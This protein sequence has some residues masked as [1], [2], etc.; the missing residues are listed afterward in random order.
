MKLQS[1]VFN[2]HSLTWSGLGVAIAA[3][4]LLLGNIYYAQP[5]LYEIAASLRIELD[6]S[7]LL[8]AF[9]Q[10]G[11]IAGLLL[12]APLGD[13]FDNRKL[14][15]FMCLG[16]GV[17][18]GLAALGNAAPAFY[19]CIFFM[20]L[21]ATATQILVVFITS[22]AGARNAGK[23]LGIMANGLFLGIALSRPA[24]S[25]LTGI[26]WWQSVDGFSSAA[27]V[28]LAGLLYIFLP[29]QASKRNI[30]PS[31][32]KIIGSMIGLTLHARNFL[33]Y[34]VLSFCAFMGFTMFWSS[35]P[36]FLSERMNCTQNF[37]TFFTMAG[38]IT[39]LSC[40]ALAVCWTGVRSKR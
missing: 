28:I 39:P 26:L 7:G 37:I 27:L 21:F 6:D 18:A 22:L 16:A 24:S 17:F 20:G 25:F 8:V 12:G 19:I 11:Y 35:A 4:C 38:L 30:N 5:I 3:T 14:C 33:R 31:Y 2:S 15:V 32:F 13:V 23:T 1:V 9:G 34:T 36:L 40:L 10:I 29:R